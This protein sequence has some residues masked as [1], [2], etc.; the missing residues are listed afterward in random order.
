MLDDFLRNLMSDQPSK[1]GI[2][3]GR[4]VLGK[5]A[6]IVGIGI[7][8]MG[9]L[10]YS[11]DDIWI[12]VALGAG[13]GVLIAYFIHVAFKYAT[14]FPNHAVLENVQLVQ[15][16]RIGQAA[17]DK[18]VIIDATAEPITNPNLLEHKKGKKNA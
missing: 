2:Q 16:L 1:F 15:A 11:I 4:G 18:S 13:I 14:A 3:F 9:G 5:T 6:P 12:R 8:V 10:A 17:S 7:L